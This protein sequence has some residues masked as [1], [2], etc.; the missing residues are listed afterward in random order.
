MIRRFGAHSCM[1]VG[2]SAERP[3]PPVSI[4]MAGPRP[5]FA[6]Y[7]D[8]PLRGK[9]I[10]ANPRYAFTASSDGHEHPSLLRS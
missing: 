3:F 6:L 1:L 7:G 9:V 4:Q 5:A 8:Q 10:P 2:P